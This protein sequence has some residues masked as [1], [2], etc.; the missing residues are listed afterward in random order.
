MVQS[1]VECPTEKLGATQMR[2]QLQVPSVWQ[3][4]FSP[5]V[6]FQCRLYYSIHIWPLCAITLHASTSVSTLKIPNIGLFG[7]IEI[8]HTINNT[9]NS[10]SNA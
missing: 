7:P 9:H 5:R 10:I 1:L 3:D 6:G 8:L 2:V 4:C